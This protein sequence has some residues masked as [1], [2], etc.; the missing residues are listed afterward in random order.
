[1]YFVNYKFLLKFLLLVV[2]KLKR[3]Q[4]FLSIIYI[5]LNRQKRPIFNSDLVFPVNFCFLK[6]GAIIYDTKIHNFFRN[7]KFFAY[8]FIHLF[9]DIYQCFT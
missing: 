9:I 5:M 7:T 4:T 3:L 8:Y 2:L 1:M 6:Y